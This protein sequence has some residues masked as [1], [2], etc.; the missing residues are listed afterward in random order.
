V[1]SAGAFTLNGTAFGVDINPAV[2]RLRIVSNN[3]QNL[4]INPN[5]GTLTATDMSLN[6]AGN[7]VA[8]A[9]SNNFV[10]APST[11]LYSIDSV[12]GSLGIITVP[13]AGGPIT[14]VGSLGLNNLSSNLGFDI[15]GLTGIAYA[16]LSF[17]PLAPN[18]IGPGSFLYQINLT[19][20]AA[21]LVGTIGNSEFTFTSITAA[22]AI[23]EPSSVLLLGG[24]AAFLGIYGRFRSVRG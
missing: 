17:N 9:Y 13:N 19:T 20:G 11:T 14:T 16:C 3:E 23:P 2:D 18:G 5:D 21:T 12:S 15:S 1:G 4:R 22:T 7:V 6:P 8:V 10:G 24:A